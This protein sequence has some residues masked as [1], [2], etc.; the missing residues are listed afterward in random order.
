MKVILSTTIMRTMGGLYTYLHKE[1][2]TPII[3]FPGIA[4]EDTAWKE[5][6]MPVEV[7]CNFI[8]GYYFL[9]FEEVRLDTEEM[10][11]QEMDMY[12]LHDWKKPLVV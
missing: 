11:K 2:E 9:K 1:M 10:C 3:P 4:V 12:V 8:E 6:K 7:I 5:P